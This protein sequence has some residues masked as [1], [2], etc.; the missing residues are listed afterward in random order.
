MQLVT[1]RFEGHS[2]LSNEVWAMNSMGNEQQTGTCIL[3]KLFAMRDHVMLTFLISVLWLQNNPCNLPV[4]LLLM[5]GRQH[6][7]LRLCCNWRNHL[8]CLA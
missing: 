2:R 5:G 1:T 7:T 6:E 3:G 8:K 4:V